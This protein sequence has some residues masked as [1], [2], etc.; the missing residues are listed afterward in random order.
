M[1]KIDPSLDVH[2]DS[3]RVA[4]NGQ[5]PNVKQLKII[6]GTGT[7]NLNVLAW[8]SASETDLNRRVF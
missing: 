2:Y 8:L 7:M 4:L 3:V 5:G 6:H 1:V